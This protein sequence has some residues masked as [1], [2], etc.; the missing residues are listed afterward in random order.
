[1][2]IGLSLCRSIVGAHGG[3][4]AA[5]NWGGGAEFAF[6]LPNLPDGG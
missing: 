4:I 6:V 1:M 3:S 5:R 2:G